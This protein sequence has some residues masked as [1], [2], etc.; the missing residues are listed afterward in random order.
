MDKKELSKWTARVRNLL[1]G[2]RARL[3]NVQNQGD[4]GEGVLF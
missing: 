4:E 3:G 1:G 2:Q